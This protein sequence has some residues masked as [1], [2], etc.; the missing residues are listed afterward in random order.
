GRGPTGAAGG[1][2]TQRSELVEGEGPVGKVGGDVLD[3][4]QLGVAVGVGGLLPGLGVLEGDV[5]AGQQGTQGLAA[6]S[7]A[8]AAGGAQVC[9]EFA[10]GP[11]GEGS[12]ELGRAGG[13]RRRD[14]VLVLR[15]E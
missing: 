13:G 1:A 8:V 15:A 5:V 6:D 9:G 14:E 2:D 10:D 11:A 3:P 7:D 12:A 4:L